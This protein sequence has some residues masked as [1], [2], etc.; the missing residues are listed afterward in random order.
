M[1]L[2]HKVTAAAH[3]EI[4]AAWI[5]IAQNKHWQDKSMKKEFQLTDWPGMK[6]EFSSLSA[7]YF[8]A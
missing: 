8:S 6:T 1:G 5:G 2:H 7:I 3:L 4:C